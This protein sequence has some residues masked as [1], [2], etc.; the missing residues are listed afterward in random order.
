MAEY[1]I[2]DWR[3]LGAVLRDARRRE[4]LTQF[5]L[6][7]RAGVSRAWLA[8]LEAGGH[9]RAEMEQVF[10]LLSALSLAMVV[11]EGRHST[12]ESAVLAA[13]GRAEHASASNSGAKEA[14]AARRAAQ[15]RARTVRSRRAQVAAARRAAADRARTSYGQER[16]AAQ[17]KAEASAEDTS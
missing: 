16:A 12:G 13:V 8:K 9:R 15:D 3:K 7:D 11:R 1:V 14:S 4:G 17:R 5:E 10:L 6:A 2:T